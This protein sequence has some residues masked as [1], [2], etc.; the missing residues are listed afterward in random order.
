MIFGCVCTVT[1][2]CLKCTSFQGGVQGVRIC[3]N[4]F[5]ENIH[6]E[7]SVQ[8]SMNSIRPLEHF[9]GHLLGHLLRQMLFLDATRKS[10]VRQTTLML[11]P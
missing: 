6:F 7:I 4:M 8:K 11:M 10:A 5:T 1:N 2:S 3:L 9:L